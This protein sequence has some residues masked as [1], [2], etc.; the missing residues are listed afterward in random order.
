MFQAW[1]TGGFKPKGDDDM[2]VCNDFMGNDEED[3]VGCIDENNAKAVAANIGDE[4]S[5]APKIRT[6][7]CF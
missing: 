3:V 2:T 6:F 7:D 5:V 4:D 1:C